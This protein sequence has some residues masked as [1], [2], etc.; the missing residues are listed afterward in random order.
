MNVLH[1]INNLDR[2][3]AQVMV[4][5]LVTANP[6]SQINYSVCARRPGGALAA[7]LRVQGVEVQAPPEYYGFR[8]LRKSVSYLQRLCRDLRIDIVHAHM[9][10]AACL[11][12]LVARKLKLPLVISHHGQDILLRCNPLCRGVY[13]LLL[14]LAARYAAMNVAVSPPV[15]ARIRKMLPVAQQRIQVIPNGVRI[16]EDSQLKCEVT[17]VGGDESTLNL[18]CVGR[19]IPLKGQHQLICAVA[20]LLRRFPGV[21]LYLVGDGEMAAALKRLAENERVSRHVEFTG[22]VDDVGEY[23]S[24]ADVYLSNS[25]SEG[26]PVSVLEAMAWR[27][28]VVASTIPGH[29]SVVNHGENGFLFALDDIDD[30]VG[31]I[32]R[33]A[34]NRGLASDV[35][36]RARLM[37][38]Q[39]YS[40]EASEREHA[41]LYRHI[42]QHPVP[43]HQPGI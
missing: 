27:L 33:I 43:E 13:Y 18:I 16:P 15:A 30:L 7:E 37:V 23:L 17:G 40:A 12:W 4:R 2:E 36:S 42:Q 8:S 9:A 29:Q 34:E 1:V 6:Q 38:M 14:A 5:N 11:G 32:V 3:G 24:R 21:R 41:R 31:N 20:R 19:L 26:M 35:A 10:D 39:H 25:R 22:T 28:P